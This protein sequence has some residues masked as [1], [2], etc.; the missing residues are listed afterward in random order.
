MTTN[1]ILS[2]A[3][4]LLLVAC[5]ANTDS[6]GDGTPPAGGTSTPPASDTSAPPAASGGA[7]YAISCT[8]EVTKKGIDVD[9]SPKCVGGDSGTKCGEDA[10]AAQAI[11]IRY[12]PPARKCGSVERF[13]WDG[14]ACKKYLTND[15][16]EMICSGADCE[17][18]FETEALCKAAYAACVR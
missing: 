1:L 10:C 6:T 7:Q 2:S 9:L 12:V 11:E 16:G 4:G 17:G 15:G 5:A 13:A 18:L 8:G 3:L 14:T